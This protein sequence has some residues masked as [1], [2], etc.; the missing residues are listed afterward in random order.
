MHKISI[1][2]KKSVMNF[3]GFGD[4]RKRATNS[5][6]NHTIQIP[7]I[8]FKDSIISFES[9]ISFDSFLKMSV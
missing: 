6:V 5:S 8:Q 3:N 9:L 4:D 2:F 7:S 1:M